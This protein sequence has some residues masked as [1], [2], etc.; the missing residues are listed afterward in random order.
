MK[1]FSIQVEPLSLEREL[2]NGESRP[3]SE[4]FSAAQLDF[5][6]SRMSGATSGGE[7]RLNVSLFCKYIT[8]GGFCPEKNLGNGERELPHTKC[9]PGATPLAV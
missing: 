4:Y 5:Q 7:G 9:Y 3:D 1:L 6:V 2:E 8:C